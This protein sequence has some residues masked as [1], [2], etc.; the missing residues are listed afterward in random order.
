MDIGRAIGKAFSGMAPVTQQWAYAKQQEQIM[1]D[2]LAKLQEYEA[3]R[4]KLSQ[5]FEASENQKSRD[6]QEKQLTNTADFQAQSLKLNERGVVL[7]ESRSVREEKT[8]N[9][10]ME[11]FDLEKKNLK[12]QY[13]AGNITLKAAERGDKLLDQ[14]LSAETEDDKKNAYS[15]LVEYQRIT[16]ALKTNLTKLKA[17]VILWYSTN[18]E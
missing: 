3:E 13:K 4:T 14:Y 7:D 11:A 5:E 12:Q 6:I 1:N 16:G 10:Q 8:A 17:P 15:A 2:R 9:K 18:A